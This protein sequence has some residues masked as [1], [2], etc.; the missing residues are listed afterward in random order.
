MLRIFEKNELSGPRPPALAI[1]DHRAYSP[2]EIFSYLV[3]EAGPIGGTDRTAAD[4]RWSNG[5]SRKEETWD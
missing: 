2:Y 4:R 5:F 1:F 3:P